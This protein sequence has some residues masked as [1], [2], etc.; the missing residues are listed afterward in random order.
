MSDTSPASPAEP[1]R[2]LVRIAHRVKVYA[3]GR[4]RGSTLLDSPSRL[5]GQV[6]LYEP[7]RLS[8]DL[9][10]AWT[11]AAAVR[12]GGLMPVREWAEVLSAACREIAR[13]LLLEAG[14]DWSG[15]ERPVDSH[16]Q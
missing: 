13:G 6:A 11:A 4:V 9:A 12:L 7:G 5:T 10:E 3:V 15:W 2:S 16:I 1:L 8:E 14:S